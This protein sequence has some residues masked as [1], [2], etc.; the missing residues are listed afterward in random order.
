MTI[1]PSEIKQFTFSQ[2]LTTVV[3]KYS[4]ST[5]FSCTLQ[6]SGVLINL[7]GDEFIDLAAA[8]AAA[9]AQTYTDPS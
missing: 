9:L 7:T 6:K 8:V 2:G 3:K 4:T 1:T 5:N